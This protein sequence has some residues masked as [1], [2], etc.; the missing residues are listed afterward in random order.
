M[1]VCMNHEHVILPTNSTNKYVFAVKMRS[2][3]IKD[4]FPFQCVLVEVGSMRRKQS[5]IKFSI[6]R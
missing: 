4:S 3:M 1:L 5:I 2:A 6:A